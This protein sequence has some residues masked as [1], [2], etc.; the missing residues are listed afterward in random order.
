MKSLLLCAAALSAL[1]C[2]A[3]A[4]T[5]TVSYEL[6]SLPPGELY[7]PVAQLIDPSNGTLTANFA[8]ND[9]NVA[10]NMTTGS[11]IDLGG[12]VV[13]TIDPTHGN[14]LNVYLSWSN[15]TSPQG[16]VDFRNTMDFPFVPSWWTV[17]GAIYIDDASVFDGGNN[18]NATAIFLVPNFAV[19]GPG[20][21]VFNSHFDVST[22]GPYSI[23]Q[24]FSFEAHPQSVPPLNPVPLPAALPMFL[25]GLIGIG[26]LA[27]RARRT[28]WVTA[29]KFLDF[30]RD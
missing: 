17:S 21:N 18:V 12:R 4:A 15:I 13:P 28:R 2:P 23:T 8:A 29:K 20:L 7:P 22:L 9:F 19:T 24:V 27:R 11:T 10:A 3:D 5:L 25:A 1:M 26:A 30:E 6:T 16:P 14:S